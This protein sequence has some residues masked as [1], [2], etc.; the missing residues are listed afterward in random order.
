M[1]ESLELLEAK[2]GLR[3]FWKVASSI[4]A[5][6]IDSKTNMNFKAI[7]SRKIK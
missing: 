6:T 5:S 4:D 1:L 3:A 7:L 2:C